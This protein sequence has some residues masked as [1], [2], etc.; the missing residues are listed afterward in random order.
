[1]LE[2][3]A[4][5][6]ATGVNSETLMSGFLKINL[7]LSLFTLEL[8]LLKPGVWI[9][10]SLAVPSPSH[11]WLSRVLILIKVFY[12]ITAF[13]WNRSV[14]D[15]VR[16]SKSD[17]KLSWLFFLSYMV[18]F[19]LKQFTKDFGSSF[20]TEGTWCSCDRAKVKISPISWTESFSK[21]SEIWDGR[22]C[23]NLL[24][25]EPSPW[26]LEPVNWLLIPTES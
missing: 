22:R 11:S 10:S 26:L 18:M 3:E 15:W 1:M 13:F 17:W 20:S 19:L 21:S 7:K 25:G 16:L 4:S 2:N 5:G 14:G 6:W 12:L 9:T 8:N 23:T 24:E